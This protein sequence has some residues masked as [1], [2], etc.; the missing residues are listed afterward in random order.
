M[1]PASRNW[2]FATNNLPYFIPPTSHWARSV[3]FPT[4]HTA[5]EFALRMFLALAAGIL[6]TYAGLSWG[7]WMRRIRR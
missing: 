4:E 3:W 5:A 2:F 1:S 7:N 6:M